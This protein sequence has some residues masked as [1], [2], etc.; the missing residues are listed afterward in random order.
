MLEYYIFITLTM[1]SVLVI[2]LTV[3][4]SK[5]ISLK[6]SS[7]T[8]TP[9][10]SNPKLELGL[11]YE[12]IEFMSDKNAIR[13]WYIRCD[14]PKFTLVY[15][16]GY[17]ENRESKILPAYE[18][19]EFINFIGGNIL[20]FDYSGQGESD[21][22]DTKS[23]YREQYDLIEAV[24]FA[25]LKSDL[26][27]FIHGISMG[28][29]IGIMAISKMSNISGLICDSPF[30]NLREYLKYNLKVW[31]KLPTI[32]FN[33]LII[34]FMEKKSGFRA[35][36]ISPIDAIKNVDIPVLLYHGRGDRVIPYLESQKIYLNNK[37]NIEF[38]I[39][40]SQG[41]CKSFKKC[42]KEYCEIYVGF[43]NS[44]IENYYE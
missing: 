39:I 34:K 3:Y 41:H 6:L 4:I 11:E 1:V 26:P 32:P 18:F 27:I 22:S 7:P 30:S 8:R 5:K 16:H 20:T 17:M 14:K 40:D 31:T 9:I 29:S 25:K 36:E 38:H 24:K 33:F 19:F 13:G 2:Y 28:A 15:S 12:N 21:G 44:I 43:L 10:E 42:R 23:G 37:K 35:D